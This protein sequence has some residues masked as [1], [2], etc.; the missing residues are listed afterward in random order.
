[1]H[2]S[3]ENQR[4]HSKSL[5]FPEI[6]LTIPTNDE[7]YVI[8]ISPSHFK[9]S[10]SYSIIENSDRIDSTLA[11]NFLPK[12]SKCHLISMNRQES[13]SNTEKTEYSSRASSSF[14]SST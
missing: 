1:M 14:R 11:P 3:K 5:I 9:S 2:C 13:C 8:S 12:N 10:N 4:I 7:S 6:T